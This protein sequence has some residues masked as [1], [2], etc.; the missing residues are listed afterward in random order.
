MN[1][2][3]K[4]KKPSAL[5]KVGNFFKG[6]TSKVKEKYKTY[7]KEKQ[8]KR[9]LKPVGMKEI[10]VNLPKT[11]MKAKTA[12][13]NMKHINAPFN[14]PMNNL[15]AFGNMYGELNYRENINKGKI[16][17]SQMTDMN[18]Q[19]LLTKKK[20]TNKQIKQNR[21]REEYKNVFG[22]SNTYEKAVKEYLQMKKNKYG[23][24]PFFAN[25]DPQTFNEALLEGKEEK[26]FNN[27]FQKIKYGKY[28][29]NET[30][31]KN[32]LEGNI[33]NTELRLMLLKNRQQNRA[34]RVA[35]ALKAPSLKR[36]AS[37][38][39][40]YNTNN[41]LSYIEPPPSPNENAENPRKLS[42]A[43]TRVENPWNYSR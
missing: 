27:I 1:W 41:N 8:K 7:Q 5:K 15:Q 32:S 33:A 35:K 39:P 11:G 37:K 16:P 36:L 24:S 25:T 9:A 20:V 26:E 23:N 42:F 17:Y 21:K 4:N 30:R 12:K 43:P 22:N 34:S 18:K 28:R 10:M 13:L 19:H 29:N 3:K 40:S 38:T 14:L 31:R 2:T 6:V